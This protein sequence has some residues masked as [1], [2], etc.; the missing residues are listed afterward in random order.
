LKGHDHD[1]KE[2]E[3]IGEEATRKK[4]SAEGSKEGRP[5]TEDEKR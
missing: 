3:Q 1:C 5:G 2:A 4:A